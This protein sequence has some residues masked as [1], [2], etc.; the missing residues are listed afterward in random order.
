M[1]ASS[2]CQHAD[3]RVIVDSFFNT[4]RSKKKLVSAFIFSSLA[5]FVEAGAQQKSR[6]ES[7]EPAHLKALLIKNT[8]PVIDGLLLDEAWKSAPL[9]ENFHEFMPE[10][11]RPVRPQLRT[12]VQLLINEDALIFGIRA[13]DDAPGKQQS[14]LARRDKVGTEQDFIGIWLDPTG[15]GRAA[16]FVRVNIA[17]VMSDG[18]YRADEDETDLGP[19]F[20]IDAAVQRL[21]DGYSMEVRWPLSNLR[22]PYADGKTWRAMIERSVPHAGALLLTSTPLTIDAL[23]HIAVL[24]EISGME[25]TVLAV[26]D[27][28][29]L[30]IK[31]ELTMRSTRD[32]DKQ[33]QRHANRTS[34]G[35]EINARPRA[36]WVFNGTL[37]PDYSQVE[38]DEPT[39]N[40]ASRIALSLPEKRG[41][42]LESSDVLGLPLAAFYSRTVVDPEWGLRATWRAAKADATAMSLRD[43]EGGVIQRGGAYETSEFDQTSRTLASLVRARWHGDGA[44]LGAFV[45][46]RDYGLAGSNHVTGFD[47]QWRGD[48]QQAAWLLMHSKTN[49]GFVEQASQA[50]VRAP[51]RSGTYLSAKFNHINET[52]WNDFLLEASSPGFINDNGFVPQTGVVTTKINVNRR[53][54]QHRLELES[55]S[56]DLYEVEAHLGLHEIRTLPDPTLGQQVNQI[57]ERKVQ[58]GISLRA[59]RQTDFW[60]NLGFDQQRAHREGQLHNTPAVHF[61]FGSSPL[62]WLSK[63]NAEVTLGRQLDVDADR[64]GRGGNATAEMGL[65]FSLPRGWAVEL[66]PRW[67]RAWVQG[68]LGRPAFVDNS[69]RWLGMLHFTSTDSLRLLAQNT[70]AA[71]SDDG[72]SGLESWAERQVHRSLL[73]RHLWRHGRSLSVGYSHDRTREPTKTNKSLT[74]KFQWEV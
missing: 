50:P 43:R 69:W 54:G 31:P 26:R 21:A 55:V 1:L 45:S 9:F 74:L 56:L 36:D 2:A 18:I 25:G 61:G 20:P 68:T 59:S 11:G 30:E 39:S 7:Q 28:S 47:G 71:R 67:N 15:H 70:A 34:L 60:A 6:D 44:L 3:L 62:P 5:A 19:D 57:I 40:G 42:F 41:F 24:Q 52:W 64:V 63:L 12:T 8:S 13:W 4:F 72:V 49:V 66:E 14:S 46:Q 10:S 73:Y 48:G 51:T 38:I 37:N 65:R 29:F 53:L 32:A 33:G 22:F 35:L 58:P 16:Q 23:S 27:R 17:G